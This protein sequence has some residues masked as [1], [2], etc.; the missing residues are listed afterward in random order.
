MTDHGRLL[1]PTHDYC[2]VGRGSEYGAEWGSWHEQ[3]FGEVNCG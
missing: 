1:I 2:R 3:V